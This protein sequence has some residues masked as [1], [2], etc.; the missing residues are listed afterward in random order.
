MDIAH[1][2]CFDVANY[3]DLLRSLIARQRLAGHKVTAVAPLG[4]SLPPWPDADMAVRADLLLEPGRPVDACLIGGGEIIRTDSGGAAAYR[5]DALTDRF[6]MPSL[7]LG[8]GLVAERANARLL[9]NAPAVPLPIADPAFQ[10]IVAALL[11]ASNY[12]SVCDDDSKARLGDCVHGSVEILSEIAVVPDT[13]VDIARH[14]PR[15]ALLSHFEMLLARQGL[16]FPERSI[17]FHL[18]GF[19]QADIADVA[20]LVTG[21][22]ES[23]GSLPILLSGVSD[24]DDGNV[25]RAVAASL[26]IPHLLMDR[27]ATLRDIAACLAFGNVHVGPDRCAFLTSFAY[28]NMGVL[29]GDGVP[30][31]LACIMPDSHGGAVIC[32]EWRLAAEAL[33]GLAIAGSA[34]WSAA[35]ARAQ[36]VLDGHWLR[37]AEGLAAPAPDRGAQ[38]RQFAGAVAAD[39]E[40]S[41]G[42]VRRLSGI[43]NREAERQRPPP[44]VSL[45]DIPFLIIQGRP[46]HAHRRG[47]QLVVH[48]RPNGRS[49]I[50]IDPIPLHGSDV[51]A[52]TVTLAHAEGNPVRFEFLLAGRD[53]RPLANTEVVVMAKQSA[54]WRLHVPDG[55]DGAG[56]LLVAT[57]MANAGDSS[58]FAWAILVDLVLDPAGLVTGKS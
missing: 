28:G 38:R 36:R 23:S 41:G 12:I 32:K 26:S 9:W 37:I 4:G 1:F 52:G 6:A 50:A 2:G 44:L 20:A 56:L 8:A 24:G 31:W 11:R 34:P 47:Q 40:R 35:L 5:R 17:L 29:I 7:W 30:P 13:L 39:N 18:H 3:G 57:S 27:P 21:M 53:G 16:N 46:E 51:V 54:S 22:S 10:D 58:R 42:W 55:F 45:L 14:W 33:A 49:E 25:A 19:G 43:L 15:D 48:P